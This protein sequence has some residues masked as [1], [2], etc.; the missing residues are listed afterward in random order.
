MYTIWEVPLRVPAGQTRGT[1]F[2]REKMEGVGRD[3][4]TARGYEASLLLLCV[5]AC[6]LCETLVM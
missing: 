5:H 4:G 3:A 1:T 6:W 2:G